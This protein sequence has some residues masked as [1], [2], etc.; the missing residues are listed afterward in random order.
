MA[1]G[2]PIYL[3]DKHGFPLPGDDDEANKGIHL[4]QLWYSGTD[5]VLPAKL[6]GALEG[7]ERQATW[8]NLK[9]FV[10]T[11]PTKEPEAE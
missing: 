1:K 6:K 2:P 4:T 9:A 10:D 8:D 3:A 11:K 5:T 7:E